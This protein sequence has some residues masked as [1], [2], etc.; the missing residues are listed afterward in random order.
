MHRGGNTKSRIF[1]MDYEEL[2]QQNA[3]K[4]KQNA[5]S[6]ANSDNKAEPQDEKV[7]SVQQAAVD[8]EIKPDSK[9]DDKKGPDGNPRMKAMEVRQRSFMDED[10]SNNNRVRDQQMEQKKW[11]VSKVI[12]LNAFKFLIF[13][14]KPG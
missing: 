11:F 2:E 6:K 8:A 13:F 7:T 12:K 9:N 3:Q 1:G 5:L 10:L 14:S 4:K